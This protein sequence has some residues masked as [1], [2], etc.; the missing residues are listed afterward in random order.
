[1]PDT[2]SRSSTR[3][4]GPFRSR[5]ATMRA[6]STVPM[7]GSR[8]RSAALAVFR[9]IGPPGAG[10]VGPAV[11][12][13]AAGV[14]PW[15]H[16]RRPCHAGSRRPSTTAGARS[17]WSASPLA[18][19][20]LG[21]DW[22]GLDATGAPSASAALATADRRPDDTD[23]GGTWICISSRSSKARLGAAGSARSVVPPARSIR[24]ATRRP[25]G[26]VQPRPRHRR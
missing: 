11:G 23:A 5:S 4:K 1:M 19:W 9:L 13:P 6:A 24:S 12:A 17:A 21:G 3:R 18:A 14:S 10:V 22:R 7:P 20:P 26:S 2:R 16:G 15:R 8:S 25:G